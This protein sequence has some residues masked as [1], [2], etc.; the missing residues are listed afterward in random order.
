M[1]LYTLEGLRGQ[2]IHKA[3]TEKHYCFFAL[4]IQPRGKRSYFT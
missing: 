3:T 4:E 1:V 2:E